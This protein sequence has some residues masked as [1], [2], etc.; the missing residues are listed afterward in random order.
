MSKRKP[1]VQTNTIDAYYV[2]DDSDGAYYLL[3]PFRRSA[4]SQVDFT[5]ELRDAR[6]GWFTRPPAVPQHCFESMPETSG[7]EIL[8][9]WVKVD[10][11][12]ESK[13]PYEN[14]FDPSSSLN[15]CVAVS[16]RC[17]SASSARNLHHFRK[18][19]V[20]KRQYAQLFSRCSSFSF[21]F[22]R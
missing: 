10:Y 1:I 15:F 5:E 21:R 17:R 12:A 6:S 9:S 19:R 11:A 20:P 13:S 8:C 16:V 7:S 2:G 3:R 22:G 4:T 14:Y 18:R